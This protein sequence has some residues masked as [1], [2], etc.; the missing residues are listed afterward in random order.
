MRPG[1]PSRGGRR[2]RSFR[3]LRPSSIS[4]RRTTMPGGR[5]GAREAGPA[6]VPSLPETGTLEGSIAAV[7]AN[8]SD[9]R[10]FS[11]RVEN[12]DTNVSFRKSDYLPTLGV[13]GTYQIDG[14][15]GSLSPH[16]RNWRV[17]EGLSCDLVDG[18]RREAAG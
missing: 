16:N 11:L 5:G 8:R 10:A 15:D 3:A 14:Q 7:R 1:S 9:L 6:P 18:L 12:A 2:S 17:G 4:G 13:T